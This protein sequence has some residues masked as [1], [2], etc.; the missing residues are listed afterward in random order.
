MNTRLK[1]ALLLHSGESGF[2]I[3]IAVALGLIMILVALTMTIRSQGDQIL[4]STRK[5]TERSLAAAEKGVSYYQAFL[6]S[7]RLLPRYPDCTQDRTSSGSCPDSGS[8]KSW[9]NPSAIPGMSD[10]PCTGS[11]AS[12]ATIQGNADTNQ[13][14][15]VDTNDSTKGQY[16]LVSYKI[17]DSGDDTLQAMGILTIEGRITNSTANSKAN[18]SISRVQVAIPVNL[19]SINSVPIPGVWIGDST[20]SSGTG[21][22]TIQGNV[23]VNSCNVTLSDIEIDR[24]TPQYSAMYTNLTMPSVPTMPAAA[25]NSVTPRVAGTISLGTINTDTTLPRLTGDTPDLPIT[26]NGQ[27]RYVYLATDI[28]RSGGSTA[29]TIT[30]GKKVVI[31]LSGNTSKNVDIYHECGS[32]SGC[33]PTD[34][35][36]FGTKPSGGEICLNGNHLV[37]AFILA[38]TY[39]VG[40]AGGGNSAGINGSIWANQWSNDSGCGSNSNNVVVRQSANWSE[41]TGLQPDSSELPLSIKSI[42]SWKRNVVN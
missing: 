9:S 3:V 21:G 39:T 32:V 18:K 5:E 25:N 37:D 36:I 1:M 15:L 42:R 12:T 23:L 14:N 30:P 28:V 16:K 8:Q 35:Q 10:S 17:A 6:N 19:P 34:F 4:A 24:T 13:W 2:A 31:F 7:N 11:S 33:L 38:P 40:V 26:F 29:L 20:T 22:N 41:L 27:S